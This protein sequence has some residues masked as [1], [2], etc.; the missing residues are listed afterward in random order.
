[1]TISVP[2]SEGR[3]EPTGGVGQDH[4]PRA[5]PLEQ[6]HRLDD[7]PGIVALVQVEPTLEHDDRATGERPSSRRPTWPGAVAAGQP[8]SSANGIATASSR[9]SA[10]PPSPDPRTIPTSG[11]MVRPGPDG[12]L[13]GGEPG[14]L[15]DRSDG[16]RRI[17]RDRSGRTCG[18]PAAIQGFDGRGR[19]ASSAR[20]KYRHRDADHVPSGRRAARAVVRRRSC[21]ATKRPKRP[22]AEQ[23]LD[24][25]SVPELLS[26][27]SGKTYGRGG[28][29]DGSTRLSTNSG[30]DP[31]RVSPRVAAGCGQVVENA[32][33]AAH[34]EHL[35]LRQG[36]R[37]RG[38]QLRVAVVAA[39]QIDATSAVRSSSDASERR[40]AR[41]SWP[42]TANRH[43]YSL[44]SAEIRARVQSRQNGWVT[45]EM[46]PNSPPPSA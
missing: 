32:R 37:R 10:R 41:R 39:P 14:G 24:A 7:E 40:T 11:T 34:R 27:P 38:A 18:P 31:R 29:P 17:D 43:V 3:I 1:M 9:S 6:E 21:T 2:G 45:D 42:S 19:N 15:V 12:G 20:R 46:T 16:S 36:A 35:D 25:I 44:P 8:G 33:S 23:V 30:R 22:A 5:Q 4:D 13:E 26:A 28:R